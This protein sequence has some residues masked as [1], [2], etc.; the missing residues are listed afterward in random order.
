MK[1]RF[2]QNLV[3]YVYESVQSGVRF[4][5]FDRCHV[6]PLCGTS[7]RIVGTRGPIEHVR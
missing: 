2:A 1:D 5:D 3:D 6:N 7:D 4:S